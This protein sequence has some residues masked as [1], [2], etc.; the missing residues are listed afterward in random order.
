M[1]ELGAIVTVTQFKVM[2]SVKD[3]LSFTSLILLNDLTR[4]RMFYVTF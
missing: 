4:V 2:V 3:F 1:T